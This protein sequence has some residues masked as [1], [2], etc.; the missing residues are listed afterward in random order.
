MKKIM[1]IMAWIMVFILGAQ[2]GPSFA[3][4]SG[5]AIE[6][7]SIVEKDSEVTIRI[8]FSHNGNSFFHHTDWAKVVV[9]QKEVARWDFSGFKKPEAA[10]FTREVKIKVMEDLEVVAEANCNLH[11]SK[12][13]VTVKITVK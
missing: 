11:G 4:K 12:G 5:A 8:T 13:P 2:V 10:S 3:D 1:L 7:P 6:A 9:N